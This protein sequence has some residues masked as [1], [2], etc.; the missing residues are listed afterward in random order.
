MKRKSKHANSRRIK[1]FRYHIVMVTTKS[2]KVKKIRHP[3]YAF[4][5]KGNL[6]I[7]VNITHSKQV[8]NIELIELRKNPR[9]K[10]K[11]K[12]YRSKV[13]RQDTKDTFGERE[14]GWHIDPQDDE[15]IRREYRESQKIK[16]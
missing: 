15:D 3:A 1:E 4:L 2:K 6:F 13:F 11:K 10:D 5:E 7:Y 16:K 9:P 14:R 8:D 12:S